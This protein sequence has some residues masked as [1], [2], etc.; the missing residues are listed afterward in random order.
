MRHPAIRVA[1]LAVGVLA[2]PFSAAAWSDPLHQR[3]AEQSARLMPRSL[4]AVLSSNLAHLHEGA[5]TASLD[6][7]SA[8]PDELE[9]ATLAQTQ[10]LLDSLSNRAPMSMV[11]HEMGVL[12][13]LVALAEDPCVASD[14]D[15]REAEWSPDFERFTEARVPKFRVVFSGYQ[16][17]ALDRDDVK[18]F[19]AD[20]MAKSRQRYPVLS[21][22]YVQGDGSI[23]RG[24]TFDERHPVFGVASLA[25]ANAISDTAKL[26]LYAWIRANG[27][28]T[29]LPFPNALPAGTPSA[30]QARG[31]R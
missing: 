12:S 23:A 2:L 20:I 29:E 13:R 31:R 21:Q 11:A 16:S 8:T 19:A 25:Y 4:Q 5:R 22:M 1:V 6:E 9:Q 24:V 27:D 3:I 28:V 26:W 10:R 14:E 7:G 17:A 18:G 15:S 30:K